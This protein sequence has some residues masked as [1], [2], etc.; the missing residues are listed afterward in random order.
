[1]DIYKSA[2][3]PKLIGIG[4]AV[5]LSVRTSADLGAHQVIISHPDLGPTSFI[6]YIPPAGMY[7]TPRVGDICY[8]FCNENFHQYPVAWGHR[9]SP[10]LAKQLIGD[11]ADNITVIYSSGADGKSVTHK[12]ELDDGS[13]NGIRITTASG[14][15][16]ALSDA[17]A[18]TVTHKDGASL[19]LTG[20]SITLEAGGSTLSVGSAGVSMASAGGSTLDVAASILGVAADKKSTFDEVGVATHNHVGNLGYPT[21][22]PL[23]GT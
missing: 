3:G 13:D 4:E 19:V 8:V 23:K 9:M 21:T 7:R 18:I 10:E 15:K 16:V 1:M 5:V 14:H 11:R 22:A 20:D 6:P 12:I 17:G 2:T